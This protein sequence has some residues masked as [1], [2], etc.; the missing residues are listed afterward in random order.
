MSA[1]LRGGSSGSADPR[2][3]RTIFLIDLGLA[4][5]FWKPGES[6][7]AAGPAAFRGSTTY[8]SVNAHTGEEQGPRDDLWSLLYML[9]ECHEGTLPWRGLRDKA[10]VGLTLPRVRVVTWNIHFCTVKQHLYWL[11]SIESHF[12]LQNNVVEKCQP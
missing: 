6:K 9:A 7:P 10:G 11:S 3:S 12:D 5:K 1:T 2:E 8:A 4:K